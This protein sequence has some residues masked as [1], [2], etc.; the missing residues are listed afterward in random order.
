[1]LLGD[2]P[3]LTPAQGFYQRALIGDPAESTYH[4]ELSLKEGRPLVTY[5]DEVA[6]EGLKLAQLDAERGA[7]DAEK[8]ERIDATVEEM[9]DN[10]ADFEPRRWFRKVPTDK[11]EIDEQE[12]G[13]SLAT[14]A[15]AEKGLEDD[16]LPTLEAADLAPGFEDEDAILC[17]GGR[18]PLDEAAAAMLAGILRRHGL[19]A[20]AVPSES[21]SAAHIVSL[22][23]SKAKLVCLSYLGTGGNH[24]P[25]RYL[26]RRLRRILP[27]GAKVLV[28][29]W[30]D[31]SE[32]RAVK[33]LEATAE[34]D[35]YATS[36]RQAAELCLN[37]ARGQAPAVVEK[38]PARV[39]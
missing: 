21:I 37:A 2:A 29:Y 23:A 34:A 19:K 6:L 4:A 8:M 38:A 20:R 25:I 10:L 24:A 26:V 31:E 11:E 17:I 39:A 15:N 3:A 18:T 9:M 36:L 32:A 27:A 22:E 12:E 33:A 30:A 7:L 5:L 28:G 16:R 1:V 35:V 13:G 14:L